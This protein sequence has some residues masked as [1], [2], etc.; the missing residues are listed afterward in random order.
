MMN[1]KDALKRLQE[2]NRQYLE[3]TRCTGDVSPQIR[4]DTVLRG[5]FPFAIIIACSDSRVIPEAIFQ[6]GIGDLFVIRVAGN[7][8]DR[9]QLGSIEY[10]AEHLG[11]K[12]AMVLGHTHCGAVD[13]AIRH[14]PAGYVKYITDEIRKAAN[15]ESDPYRAACL[16]VE[17][18]VSIIKSS[19]KADG[20][21]VVGAMADI[22]TG[23][24][25]LTVP[26]D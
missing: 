9:H 11:T 22:E 13:A 6:C 2:G 17:R 5:Q 24:V 16:N 20:L 14:E 1:A 23:E 21:R 15:G 7:V 26:M 25:T 4:Q 8:M 12:L 19:I 3:S 10:A 18:S